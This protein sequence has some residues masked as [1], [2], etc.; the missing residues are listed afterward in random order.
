M[1]KAATARTSRPAIR[2]AE[3]REEPQREPVRAKTR[4]RKG[5]GTDKFHIPREM[6]PDGIDLQW[7]TDTVV[8]M[9]A[10]Q[11]RAEMERQGWEAVTPEM[12]DGRFDGM[13]AR[14][15]HQG[16][17]NVG[18]LVLMWRP[19]ELTMEARAEE[20]Q[21]A[22]TARYIEE[23][24]IQTGNVDNVDPDM[25]DNQNPKARA[26][27]FLRKERIASMPVPD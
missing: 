27:T 18:G 16:E 22:N 1:S 11:E 5:A 26:Q 24:K 19:I 13:F 25:F 14:K 21:A 23:R 7:N 12:W 15:G 6:I 3:Q 17:I 9:A 2:E 20:L 8:G 4:V 10:V